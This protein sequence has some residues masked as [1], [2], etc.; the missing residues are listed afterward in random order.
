MYRWYEEAAVCYVYLSDVDSL[1]DL[2]KS[3]WF[4]RGWT[5]QELIVC[6]AWISRSLLLTTMF[7]KAPES[8][9]FYNCRWES[10]GT[11][12]SLAEALSGISGVPVELL[13]GA[14]A[15]IGRS[16]IRNRHVLERWS[17][18]QRMSWASKRVTTRTEDTA[19][20]LMALFDVNMPMLYGEGHKACRRLQEEIIRTSDDH[21]IFAWSCEGDGPR[22]LLASSPT[23]FEDCANTV[24]DKV[25]QKPGITPEQFS[26]TNVGLSF[27]LPMKRWNMTTYLAVLDCRAEAPYALS[28][29]T[30][31]F[32]ART[33]RTGQVFR[34][35]SMAKDIYHL[36]DSYWLNPVWA[37]CEKHKILIVSR[38]GGQHMMDSYHHRINHGFDFSLTSNPLFGA[39]ANGK[40]D[41]RLSGYTSLNTNLFE[42]WH[43]WRA[44]FADGQQW[45]M[46]DFMIPE[47]TGPIGRIFF[48]FAFDF[49]PVCLLVSRA[50][51]RV[52]STM[53]SRS[54]STEEAFEMSASSKQ[55]YTNRGI[56]E[57]IE[58]HGRQ[59]PES[60][61]EQSV[62]E[63]SVL[64]V[65]EPIESYCALRASAVYGLDARIKHLNTRVKI[66][67]PGGDKS[68]AWTV[69]ISPWYES[70]L[71]EKEL[72]QY[73]RG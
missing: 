57:K 31:I 33:P 61:S 10:I 65:E 28:H 24:S 5:L 8:A 40:V 68:I 70:V 4:T 58:L 47:N 60:V 27:S 25:L 51:T 20:C 62:F 36:D 56:R 64:M 49:S 38:P 3:A 13:K 72:V 32:L 6:C 30:G 11:K 17:V 66:F 41:F 18:A 2:D 1:E 55:I 73:G 39:T 71:S 23:C 22:D 48:G 19:Y 45:T 43:L 50:Q 67:L 15:K 63:P 12:T 42:P 35:S 16:A 26:L 69:I 7:F 54:T 44:T 9:T 29:C 34:T 59:A 53:K 52:D 46:M 14:T 37:E 21:S